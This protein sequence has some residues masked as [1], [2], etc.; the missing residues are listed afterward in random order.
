VVSN[1]LAVNAIPLPLLPFELAPLRP[2]G[3]VDWWRDQPLLTYVE[4]TTD[5]RWSDRSGYLTSPDRDPIDRPGWQYV[6]R[7]SYSQ[8]SYRRPAVA[9]RSLPAA[10]G[11]DGRERFLRGMRH[12]SET[13]RYR[14]PYPD[15]FFEAFNQGSG[16]DMSWYFED[17]FRGTGTVDWLVNVSQRRWTKRRGFWQEDS[18][19]G[20]F[21]EVPADPEEEL[22]LLAEEEAGEEDTG[23]ADERP[24]K[25]EILVERKG[26]LRLPLP[27]R[28]TFEDGS[29]E[30]RI[31]TRE[32]QARQRWLKIE[33]TGDKKLASAVVDPER[34][35][36]L[37]LDM[38]NN[39]WFDEVDEVAPWR[40]AER[41][42]SRYVHLL[43]WQAG[44]GG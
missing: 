34:G 5:P 14:H 13:W 42:F 33:L 37:D 38:Q 44:I 36:F 1:A 23:A 10:M 7:N 9:L 11:E 20:E 18:P 12:Y 3:L 30:T 41:A 32:E 2:S 25:I 15:D 31:W 40:W 43:H 19:S 21:V 29:S 39:A 22:L 16:V 6:D 24:W 27:I 28:W 17:L 35:Y 4:Q 26:E 8:N